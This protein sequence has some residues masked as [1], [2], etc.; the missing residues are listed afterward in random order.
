MK[1]Y[2]AYIIS[3]FIIISAIP[4]S[5]A[6]AY[7]V[8][9]DKTVYTQGECI[10][11]TVTA[12]DSYFYSILIVRNETTM[13]TEEVNNPD[14]D[15]KDL[16]MVIPF[17]WSDGTDYKVRVGSGTNFATADFTVDSTK[18]NAQY[19]VSLDK[20]SVKTGDTF[21]MSGTT[22]MQN[23]L[24]QYNV[25]KQ[26]ET[27]PTLTGKTFVVNGKFIQMFILGD[28]LSGTYFIKV[29]KN[30]NYS[31]NVSFTVSGT[32][33]GGS[34]GG[35]SGGGSSGGGGS[36]GGG[37]GGGSSGGGGSGGGGSG[38]GG[39][40]GGSSGGGSSGGGGS[41]GGDISTGVGGTKLPHQYGDPVCGKKMTSVPC[42]PKSGQN[43]DLLVAGII[44]DDG[45]VK[46][47]PSSNFKDGNVKWSGEVD[48]NVA[49]FYNDTSF[50]DTTGKWYDGAA[51]YMAARGVVN[52]V[53]DSQFAPENKIDR[54]DITL[55]LVRAFAG[56]K[57]GSD[58]FSDVDAGAYYASAVSTAK[59]LGIATG[60]DGQFD[61][62]ADVT[63]Q[64]MF[65]LFARTLDAFGLLDKTADTSKVTFSDID[66][67]AD[68]AKQDILLL[69]AN[70][71]ING[72]DGTINPTGT[73]TR[74]ETAQMLTNF[75]KN[76]K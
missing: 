75:F 39:S 21:T 9:L 20:T 30:N 67:A 35:S 31:N 34:G 43:P 23:G 73:A 14:G 52:G 16:Y 36:G 74:A 71:Y 1:K 44:N 10:H 17:D 65:V 47:L 50:T 58:N 61:P 28:G 32:S 26:G 45:T 53:G 69:A 46:Y 18:D 33:G 40:G 37:S 55:M 54:A 57:K 51:K 24:V 2:I 4:V 5:A 63:R 15:T 60:S 6:S 7:S 76:S 70:G 49:V 48:G 19:T 72:T 27:D 64:D 13:M 68:Y 3:L 25:F 29:G 38:G 59:E 56:D 11:M 42:S 22:T 12:P 8:V 66:G 62:A 41:G